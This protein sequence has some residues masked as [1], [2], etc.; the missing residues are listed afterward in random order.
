MKRSILIIILLLSVM[1]APVAFPLQASAADQKQYNLKLGTHW[2]VRH[3]M[4]P[5]IKGWISDM[6]TRT[7]GRLKIKYYPADQLLSLKDA[8]EKMS[9]GIAD[10]GDM[11]PTYYPAQFPLSSVHSLPFAYSSSTNGTN[12]LMKLRPAL[13]KEY[14][15]NNLKLLW[16]LIPPMYQPILVD[17][18]IRKLEDWKGIRFRSGGGGQKM[19]LQFLGAVPVVVQTGEL[20]TSLQRGTIDGA[21]FPLSAAYAFKLNEV[22][23]HVTN[24]GVSSVAIVLCMNLDSWNSLPKDI[25]GGVMTASAAVAQKTCSTY[26]TKETAAFVGWKK[27][28]IDIYTP[29]DEELALW[30]RTVAPVWDKWIKEK[31]AKGLPAKKI[32]EKLRK[33]AVE[34]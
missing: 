13:D 1:M 26:D 25:Q 9:S 28:G 24:A 10:M 30:K 8:L 18:K 21:V 34:K 27:E 31:E 2:P 14:A 19:A 20:Y 3:L 7:Q 11:N 32:V 29:P 4:T 5:I 22:V 12:T 16:G 23:K 15:A 33:L 17:K 6:E